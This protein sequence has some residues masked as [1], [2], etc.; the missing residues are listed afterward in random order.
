L[1]AISILGLTT[2][3]RFLRELLAN[4]RVVSGTMDTALIDELNPGP[5]PDDQSDE[6]TVMAAVI[7]NQAS[8]T[9]SASS[10]AWKVGDGWRIGAE[11]WIPWNAIGP[12]ST[13]V[14]AVTRESSRGLE[15]RVHDRHIQIRGFEIHGHGSAVAEIDGVRWACSF[16]QSE[17]SIW[18]GHDGRTWTFAEVPLK[19]SERS[20][21]DAGG[22]L[23]SPMPGI[24]VAINVVIGQFVARGQS[25]CIVEAMKMEHNVTAN[26]EGVVTDIAVRVGAHVTIGQSL[27]LIE[28]LAD[29]NTPEQ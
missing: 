9:R 6:A 3:T 1:G 22:V 23:S 15:A 29:G 20:A 10:G 25:V 8:R 12:N 2:N 5:D 27:V 28:S 14:A 18:V 17:D 11:E 16:A 7:C 26:L 24:V 13:S 4:S 21:A 19:N